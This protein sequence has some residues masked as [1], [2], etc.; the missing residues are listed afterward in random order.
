VTPTSIDL[1]SLFGWVNRSDNDGTM[2]APVHEFHAKLPTMEARTMRRRFAARRWNQKKMSSRSDCQVVYLIEEAAVLC[3][4]AERDFERLGED[5]QKTVRESSRLTEESL[6]EQDRARRLLSTS[7]VAAVA[8]CL[9]RD[10][11]KRR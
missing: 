6:L 9:R 4:A 7:V 11:A 2:E 10:T 8:R 1:K 3:E 5:V